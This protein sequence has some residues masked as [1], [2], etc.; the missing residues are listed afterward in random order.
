MLR[1]LRE[2]FG[3]RRLARAQRRHDRAADELDAA[4]REVLGK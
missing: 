3:G 4:I 2:L 1:A